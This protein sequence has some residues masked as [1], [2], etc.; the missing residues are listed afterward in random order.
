[1]NDTGTVLGLGGQ[2]SLL[3]AMPPLEQALLWLSKIQ[4]LQKYL[5]AATLSKEQLSPISPLGKPSSLAPE[6]QP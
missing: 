4:T 3:P 1:M 6:G 2:H 5:K